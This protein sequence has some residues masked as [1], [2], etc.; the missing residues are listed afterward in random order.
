MLLYEKLRQQQYEIK[1]W[2]VYRY[3]CQNPKVLDN[4]KYREFYEVLDKYFLKR[5][6][7]ETE[8]KTRNGIQELFKYESEHNIV[9]NDDLIEFLMLAYKIEPRLL[10][11]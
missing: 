1:V 7:C 5:Y 6:A 9:V 4:E 11:L 8:E 10:H 3:F 2:F